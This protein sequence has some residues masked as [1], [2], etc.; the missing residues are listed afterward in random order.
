LKILS[1]HLKN[2][3]GFRGSNTIV[4]SGEDAGCLD[5]VIG[6]NGSGK[7]VLL[8]A[9]GWAIYG[10]NYRLTDRRFINA[11]SFIHGVGSCEV[12]VKLKHK[13]EILVISRSKY[14]RLDFEAEKVSLLRV[15]D[16]VAKEID[17]ADRY[18]RGL[19]DTV[20]IDLICFDWRAVEHLNKKGGISRRANCSKNRV[21]VQIRATP[22]RLRVK[23]RLIVS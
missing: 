19:L 21:W 7:T 2:V 9:L 10:D 15:A 13:K 17:E 3:G 20:F 18:L 16:G 11:P 12:R 14:N 8:D 1:A 4:F 5:L 22:S 6:G 23:G